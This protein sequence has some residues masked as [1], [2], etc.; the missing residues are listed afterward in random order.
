M[1]NQQYFQ[2]TSLSYRLKAAQR[3]LDAFRSGEAYVKLHKDYENIIRSLHTEI[4][5][6]QYERDAFSFSRK[7]ITRQWMDVLEDVQKEQEKEVKKL[8]KPS[9]NCWISSQALKI[10][11]RNWMRKEKKRC[12]IITKRQQNWKMRRE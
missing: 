5:K 2:T 10:E 12:M 6:L 1:N 3:E 4:K 7:E 8:K 11:M 9:L